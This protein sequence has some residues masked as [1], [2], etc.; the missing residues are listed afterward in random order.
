MTTNN[1]YEPTTA[2]DSMV[3]RNMTRKIAET[4]IPILSIAI[5]L[6]CVAAATIN[7]DPKKAP[8]FSGL[9]QGFGAYFFAK[10]IFCSVSLFLAG[11]TYWILVDIRS[12]F[13]KGRGKSNNAG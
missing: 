10:G 2:A 5:F 7:P 1:P 11:K 6:L 12:E 13:L 4:V 3:E 8:H 9:F